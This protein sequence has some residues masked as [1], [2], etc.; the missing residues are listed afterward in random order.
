MMLLPS[1]SKLII[2]VPL[3]MN[4]RFY[5]SNNYL[6]TGLGA[7]FFSSP[8]NFGKLGKKTADGKIFTGVISY[9]LQT[10]S[11]INAKI[12][13]TLFYFNQEFIPYGGFSFGYSF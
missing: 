1:S 6:E 4:Y 13:F 9:C 8:L 3:I 5:I 10:G 7:T 11:G 2:S 12:S